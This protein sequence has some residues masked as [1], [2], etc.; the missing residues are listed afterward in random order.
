MKKNQMIEKIIHGIFLILGLITFGCSCFLMHYGVYVN[1]L[2]NVVV[3][4]TRML[5]YLTGIFYSVEK[6]IPEIGPILNH[7]IPSAYFISSMRQSLIYQTTP[8]LQVLL[9]WF[10][11]SLLLAVAGIRKIYKEENNYVKAI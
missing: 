8:D 7:Y 9:F 5:F 2:S 10:V 11:I 6:R 3:I 4:A 1:A